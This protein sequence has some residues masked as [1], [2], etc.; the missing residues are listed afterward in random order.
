MDRAMSTFLSGGGRDNI[1]IDL[2][3]DLPRV[4]ADRRRFV[5]VLGNLLSNAAMHSPEPS[6][7]RVNAVHKG[8][9]VA[10]TVAD[11][12]VGISAERLPYLFR[13]FS[14]REGDDGDRG[15]VGSG[16]GLAICKGIVEAHG[17]RI[18]AESDGPGLGARFTFTIPAVEEAAHVAQ[19][20]PA[21]TPVRSGRA[22]RNRI[23]VLAVDDDPQTLRYVRDAL[24]EEGYVPIVTADPDAVGRLMEE[25]N[26]H[27][28]LLDLMLPGADGI[29]LMERVPELAEVPVI[30]LS[31]YGRDQI[32]ARALEAGADDYVVKPFSPTELVARIQAVLRRWTATEW[33]EPSEPYAL[34]ELTVNYAERRVSLA[35]RPVQLTDLEYRMLCELA[36]NAGRVL[37]HDLLL[38]RVW[39]LAKSGGSGPVRTVVKNLRR[40]LGDDADSPTYIF[41]EPGVG[42]RVPN[43]ESSGAEE[44]DG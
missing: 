29:E 36:A 15:L 34:G 25:E 24:T 17:G 30:F 44:R 20:G 41:N 39:G 2:P 35:G 27:L 3:P 37:S 13:K 14:R 9:H 32:V 38:Q 33:A 10:V 19:A 4:M 18:W 22:G 42:Y 21:R 26:P 6:A 7:I 31:A 12:G 23:R 1:R 8:V 40:K 11:D 43:A 5:Q 16:L 28:V